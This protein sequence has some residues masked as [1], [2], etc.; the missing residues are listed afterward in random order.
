[1]NPLSLRRE[2]MDEFCLFA[3]SFLEH[4]RLTARPRARKGVVRRPASDTWF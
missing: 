4:Q 1:M 2:R 3:A